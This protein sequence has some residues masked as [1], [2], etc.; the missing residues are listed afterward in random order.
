MPYYLSKTQ[1]HNSAQN[2]KTEKSKYQRA[3]G[4]YVELAGFIFI[5][6]M[7][8]YIHESFRLLDEKDFCF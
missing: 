8:E 4:P 2:S 7:S 1:N 5:L 3:P 6:K